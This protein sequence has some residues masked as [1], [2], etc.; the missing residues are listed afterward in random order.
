MVL[1]SASD[2]RVPTVPLPLADAVGLVNRFP[3]RTL[4]SP[5]SHCFFP[6]LQGGQVCLQA[7]P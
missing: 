4:R 5:L 1:S 6:V 7:L 2:T 3:S